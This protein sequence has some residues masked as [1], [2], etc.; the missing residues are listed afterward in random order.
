MILKSFFLSLRNFYVNVMCQH[1]VFNVLY[2]IL[3][4]RTNFRLAGFFS[5]FSYVFIITRALAVA[6]WNALLHVLCSVLHVF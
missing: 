4:S 5:F 2:V 1:F 6:V 3:V